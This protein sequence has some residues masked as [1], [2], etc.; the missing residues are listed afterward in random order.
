[1]KRIAVGQLLQETN[2]LNPLQTSRRHFEI[3]GL[4]QGEA[5]MGRYGDT[6]EPMYTTVAGGSI[7]GRISTGNRCYRSSLVVDLSPNVPS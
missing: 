2:T 7:G 4:G 6:E 1:M 5:V 3:Y